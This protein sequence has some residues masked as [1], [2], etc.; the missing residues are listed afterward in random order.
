MLRSVID[1][2]IKNNKNPFY[3]TKLIAQCNAATE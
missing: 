1:S 2:A 3:I